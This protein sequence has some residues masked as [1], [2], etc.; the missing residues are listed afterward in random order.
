MRGG[1]LLQDVNSGKE[2]CIFMGRSWTGHGYLN[3]SGQPLDRSRTLG[4]PLELDMS[5]FGYL[6]RL[7]LLWV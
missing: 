4:E 5:G 3:R 7:E 6:R 1:E 2:A